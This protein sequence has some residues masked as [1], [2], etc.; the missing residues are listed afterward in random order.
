MDGIV[1]Q[2]YDGASIMSG[3]H[4]G[5]KKLIS[6]ECQRYVIYLHCFLHRISLVVI[7]AMENITE[8]KE[9]FDI[10]SSL[11]KFFKK[12]AVLNMYEGTQLKRLIAT[13]W[14]GHFDST[15]HV[16]KNYGQIIKALH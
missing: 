14:S 15:R 4:N 3:E 9:Y 10:I 2:S 12:S 11:Y 6:E 8:I 7:H 16:N 13:R 1:S 5:L